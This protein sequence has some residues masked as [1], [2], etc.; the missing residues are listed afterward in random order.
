MAKRGSAV[1]VA[2]VGEG[3]GGFFEEDPVVANAE[4]KE[5]LELAGYRAATVRERPAL[6]SA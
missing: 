1:S 6:V 2:A 5:A 4:A 3:D